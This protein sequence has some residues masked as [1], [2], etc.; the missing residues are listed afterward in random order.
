MQLRIIIGIL[1]IS[2]TQSVRSNSALHFVDLKPYYNVGDFITVDVQENLQM[3]ARIQRV[4]LWVAILL[5]D[6]SLLFLTPDPLQPF[7][8][9][10]QAFKLSLEHSMQTHRILDFEVTTGI[11]GPYTLYAVYV[12][13]GS[14]PV[15][16][17]ALVQRSNL[18]WA[19]LILANTPIIS[20]IGVPSNVIAVADILEIHLS[21]S[22]V[23]EAQS[24]KI[25]WHSSDAHSGQFSTETPS[26]THTEL[27]SELEYT[28]QVS[29]VN[30]SGLESDLSV[31]VSATPQAV[32]Q[33][34]DGLFQD[35]LQDGSLGPEMI[36]ISEGTFSMGDIQ[37]T[38]YQNEQP[39]H[40][41]SVDAFAMGRYEITFAEYDIFAHAT[42]GRLPDDG[43]WG[44]GTRPVINVSWID[45]T[46]YTTWLSDETGKTYRLP[47]EAEWEY[48]ARAG[49]ETDYWWG[50]DIGSHQANCK[51]E[52]GDSFEYT[53]PVG[54]FDP[55]PWGLHDT[56]GNVWEWVQDWYD[57]YNSGS[58]QNPTGPN[59]GDSRLIRGG[60]WFGGAL[61]TRASQRNYQEPDTRRYSFGFRILRMP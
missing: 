41:V 2:V 5:S 7:S 6:D 23:S 59:T 46:A 28:Y 35:M 58:I 57:Y 36:W 25:Y 54:S 10:Q 8:S 53:A 48:A 20:S 31:S 19:D 3:D 12:E 50:N 55:N 60:G 32:V 21:W 16:D 38:G 34:Q 51:N 30:S 33:Q 9:E 44:R 24:Y 47:T 56:A 45:A 37:D 49:T 39:V 22:L 17:N 1:L 42:G 61:N 26:L 4:D 18:L 27:S 52:C 11:G 14:N 43:D 15:T 13:E 29:A 40:T